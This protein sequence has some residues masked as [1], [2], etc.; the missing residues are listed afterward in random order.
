MSAPL[1]SKWG[2]PRAERMEGS[3]EGIQG[4]VAGGGRP[5]STGECLL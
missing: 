2:Q 5:H 1:L 3:R 4:Q